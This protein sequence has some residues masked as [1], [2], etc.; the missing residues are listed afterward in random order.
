M[1]NSEIIEL[2]GSYKSIFKTSNGKEVLSDLR[3]FSGIDEQ[4]GS[5]LTLAQCAYRNALQDFYRY[6]EAM[7]SE[8]E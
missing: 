2:V 7:V 1:S 3:K 4:S 5:E 6:I 8:N